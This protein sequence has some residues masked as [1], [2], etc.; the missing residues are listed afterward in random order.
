M[1]APTCLAVVCSMNFTGQGLQNQP[2][3]FPASWDPRIFY[4]ILVSCFHV[5]K[6]C[7][8]NMGLACRGLQSLEVRAEVTSL[9]LGQ[10]QRILQGRLLLSVHALVA[11]PRA[12]RLST[13]D[14]V[15]KQKVQAMQGSFLA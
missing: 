2:E 1:L 10:P 14:H 3:P 12:K 11:L 5:S 9:R 6:D 15:T 4:T 13:T 7:V 8:R